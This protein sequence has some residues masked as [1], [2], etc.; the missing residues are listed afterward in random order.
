MDQ[1]TYKQEQLHKLFWVEEESFFA[2]LV[3]GKGKPVMFIGDDVLDGLWG[4]VFHPGY[5]R[6]VI[7]RLRQSD[8]NTRWGLRTRSG[9]SRQIRVNGPPSYHN[10]LV[11][12]H[13]NRIAAEGLERYGAHA[14]A[15]EI[16]E[17]I[18]CLEARHGRIECVAVGRS[19]RLMHYREQG[20]PVACK[21]QTWAVHGTLARTASLAV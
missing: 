20:I 2:P 8:M 21:P 10:G 18:A 5:A 6:K 11:W 3:D 15:R 19:G 14:F 4:E 7:Q 16:D 13:R 9:L 17:N 12:L 1:S